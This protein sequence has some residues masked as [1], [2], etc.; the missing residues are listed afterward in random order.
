MPERKGLG[1]SAL[2]HTARFSVAGTDPDGTAVVVGPAG[3]ETAHQV[4]HDMRRKGFT[5]VEVRLHY[6][7]ASSKVPLAG[8][9]VAV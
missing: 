6:S 3:V 2:G 5:T 4:A 8:M 7:M 9:S 1:D